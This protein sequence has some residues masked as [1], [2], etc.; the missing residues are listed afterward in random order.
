MYLIKNDFE[1]RS[2]MLDAYFRQDDI[3]G[4]TLLTD[5]EMDDF[6]FES[7]PQEYPCLGMVTPS[8]TNPLDS[9]IAFFYRNNINDWATSMGLINSK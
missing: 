4:D 3:F 7:R 6:L 8:K 5:E 9:D 1:Y 2:W